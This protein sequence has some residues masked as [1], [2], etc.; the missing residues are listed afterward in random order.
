MYLGGFM[1]KRNKHLGIITALSFAIYILLLLFGSSKTEY[2]LTDFTKTDIYQYIGTESEKLKL[3]PFSPE[4][5]SMDAKAN[6]SIGRYVEKNKFNKDQLA[7]LQQEVPLY[8]IEVNA[9]KQ[10]YQINPVTGQ[11]TM[12]SGIQMPISGQKEIVNFVKSYFGEEYVAQTKEI[13]DK[14][15]FEDWDQKYVFTAPASLHDI[16]KVIEIYTI[17]DAIVK[18]QHFGEANEY[19]LTEESI[20]AMITQIFS[21]L[22]LGVLLLIVTVQLIKRLRKKQ[23]ETFFWPFLWSALVGFSSF[24][25]ASAREGSITGSGVLG[26]AVM[27]YLTFATLFIRWE[28]STESK[29]T[30][31]VEWRNSIFQGFLFMLIGFSLTEL[32]LFV[33]GIFGAWKSPVLNYDLLINVNPWILPIVPLFIGLSAA[34]WEEAVFRRYMIP[35]FD[36]FSVVASVILT[37]FFW[38]IQHLSYDVYPWYLRIIEFMI[39]GSFFYF[40]YKKFGFKTAIFCHYFYN[41]LFTSLFLFRVDLKVGIVALILSISPLLVLLL[42]TKSQEVRMK[43]RC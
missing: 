43:E 19:P 33:A 24:F 25:L 38:G 12:A 29:D 5:I 32:F 27:A 17:N 26:S 11:L 9:D 3:P 6:N 37:S 28:K 20:W 35:F 14:G 16:T 23:I 31:I 40:I 18:F 8:S 42:K 22:L 10:V 15:V 41:S 2:P 36:R 4:D 7:L 13:P 30:N 21:I 34:I 39:I 1:F